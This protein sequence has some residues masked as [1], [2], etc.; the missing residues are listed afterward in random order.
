MRCKGT[1]PFV[2][3]DCGDEMA[4]TLNHM[5]SSV[6]QCL[7]ALDPQIESSPD[8]PSQRSTS[9]LR[10]AE[11]SPRFLCWRMFL[12]ALLRLLRLL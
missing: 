9:Q 3:E 1:R 2:C 10:W 6:S 4:S 8:A 7:E 11:L 5:F 12:I